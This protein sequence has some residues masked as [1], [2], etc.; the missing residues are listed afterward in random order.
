MIVFSA[1][2]ETGFMIYQ[3]L[4]YLLQAN[5]KSYI[6]IC[7]KICKK[8]QLFSRTPVLSTTVQGGLKIMPKLCNLEHGKIALEPKIWETLFKPRCQQS[9]TILRLYDT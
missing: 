4:K 5:G 7:V 1:V 8:N 6:K 3:P 9:L 2:Q